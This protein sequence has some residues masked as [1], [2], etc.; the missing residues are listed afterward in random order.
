MSSYSE[1]V[2][3]SRAGVV[4]GGLLTANPTKLPVPRES[5]GQG[6]L[7]TLLEIKVRDGVPQADVLREPGEPERLV[8]FRHSAEEPA[9]EGS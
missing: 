3:E 7:I 1:G 8:R 5:R 6:A 9:W 2:P 4:T